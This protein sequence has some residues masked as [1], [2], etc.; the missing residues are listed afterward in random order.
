M[1]KGVRSAFAEQNRVLDLRS[2]VRTWLLK[3][4]PH[5][6]GLNLKAR[7]FCFYE[8]S[9][10]IFSLLNRARLWVWNCNEYIASFLN[11]SS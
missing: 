9:G 7:H 4:D 11:L 5:R 2:S 10:L 3:I 6:A 8:K 1:A